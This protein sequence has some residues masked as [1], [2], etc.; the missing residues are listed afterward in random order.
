M[1][2]LWSFLNG[3]VFPVFNSAASYL[4][5]LSQIFYISPWLPHIQLRKRNPLSTHSLICLCIP[6]NYYERGSAPSL[7]SWVSSPLI[8]S[9]IL[10]LQLLILPLPQTSPLH[11]VTC[12]VTNFELTLEYS[13]K[14]D[15]IPSPRL[16]QK[17]ALT[18][19]W[20]TIGL[21]HF[22]GNVQSSVDTGSSWVLW[23]WGVG[24]REIIPVF[25]KDLVV[26][27]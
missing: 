15:T 1:S 18:A 7:C 22:L 13:N 5:H 10:F 9:K 8:C 24:L 14:Q 23:A 12:F 6:I 19:S 25:T 16:S 4:L 20:K 17:N 27:P 21:V 2:T 3:F 11:L 26:R